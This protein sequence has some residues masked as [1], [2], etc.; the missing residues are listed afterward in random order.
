MNPGIL[1]ALIA[2]ALFGASTPLAKIALGHAQPLMLAGLLY[3]G[4]GLGLGLW[5]LL[6]RILPGMRTR[7]E[8]RLTRR[9]VPWLAGAIL[10]G[11]VLGPALLIY[12]LQ[13]TAASTASL[14]LNLE[15]V[16]TALLAW[17]VFHENFDRRIALGM[18]A[19]TVGGIFLSW[20][21]QPEGGIPWGALAIAG[22]C[23]CWAVDNNLTRKVSAGDPVQIASLKGLVA[24][25]VNTTIAWNI[26]QAFPSATVLIGA[27]VIG[28]LGYGVSL[29]LFV[30]ALRHIGTARSGAYFLL[31]PFFGAA[32]AI[33]LLGDRVTLTFLVAA[34]LMGLGL[35]LHLTENHAHEHVHTNLEHDHVHTHDDGHHL[36]EHPE[37]M[38]VTEPHAHPHAHRPVVHTHPHY[39][40]IHH[41]HGH[42][43][44]HE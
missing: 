41:G 22:A 20:A 6:H 44:A 27:A 38:D 39:P 16:L 8:G 23:L 5:L 13:W 19:I 15:G 29:T 35:W 14:L 40:D 24:G 43:T 17:F 36:H 11:G 28:L 2:A 25:A 9:D 26:G 33:L 18:L 1:S 3:L 4:S 10:A 31:A 21:G 34:T 12:G 42:R 7:Q 37:G 30:R 32:L